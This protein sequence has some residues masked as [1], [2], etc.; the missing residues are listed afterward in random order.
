MKKNTEGEYTLLTAENNNDV[1]DMAKYAHNVFRDKSEMHRAGL[2]AMHP[3]LPL[4]KIKDGLQFA[5]KEDCKAL[6]VADVCAWAYRRYLASA[7]DA[8]RFFGPMW[9]RFGPIVGI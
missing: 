7:P 2:T 9:D 4:V 1:R 5:R 3:H 8:E 6:Q